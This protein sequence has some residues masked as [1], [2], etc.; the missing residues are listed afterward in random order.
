MGLSPFLFPQLLDQKE[1]LQLQQGEQQ[2]EEGGLR[3][4]FCTNGI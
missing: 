2:L 1:G 3:E 4:T